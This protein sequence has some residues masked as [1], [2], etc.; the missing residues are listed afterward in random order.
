MVFNRPAFDPTPSANLTVD[1]TT[2]RA[3][4]EAWL[5]VTFNLPTDTDLSTPE[6]FS[7][8]SVLSVGLSS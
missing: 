5:R 2:E 6:H 8:T 3:E 4:A 1:L 7:L